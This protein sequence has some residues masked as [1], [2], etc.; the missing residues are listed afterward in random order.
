MKKTD[1]SKRMKMRV[2]CLVLVLCAMVMTGCQQKE[3]FPNQPNPD[4]SAGQSAQTATV[5]GEAQQLFTDTEVTAGDNSGSGINYDDGSYDPASEEG[6]DEEEVL[7]TGNVLTPAPTMYSEYA[8]ATPVLIDP[9]D[10]PTPTPLP[11]LNFSFAK[12]EAPLLHMTFEAPTGWTQEATGNDTFTLTNPDPA[13]DWKA[14]LIIR[15]V[16]VAK[17]YNKNDLVKEVTGMMETIRGEGFKKFETSKTAGRVF[18]NSDGVYANYNGTTDEGVKM[19]GR[20]IA[21]CVD[22]TLYILHVTFPAG[23][24]EYYISKVYDGFRHSVKL[25]GTLEAT[26]APAGN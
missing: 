12:Y 9:I 17:Q 24:R 10:K 15:A 7:L 1:W 20:I 21:A 3:T 2:L 14:Q 8:G 22:K 19:G 13:M 26:E 4:G 16:P 5:S 6:G 25:G 23:Y 18:L 11:T